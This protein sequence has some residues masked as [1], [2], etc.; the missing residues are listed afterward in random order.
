MPIA[1][2]DMK[3]TAGCDVH[4]NR[5]WQRIGWAPPGAVVRLPNIAPEGGRKELVFSVLSSSCRISVTVST[6]KAIACR[7]AVMNMAHTLIGMRNSVMPGARML[8]IVV[9]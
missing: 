1:G 6:G 8:M 2:R 9:M 7:M 3:Y 4:H 5:C